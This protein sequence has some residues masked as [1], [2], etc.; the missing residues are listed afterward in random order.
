MKT[1]IH[2]EYFT[3]AV[4]HCANC[5][6]KRTTGATKKEIRIEI[7]SNCHPFYTGKKV[8]ID[9]EGRVDFCNDQSL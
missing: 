9:T 7:C 8:L 3:D 4:I 6:F 5:D 2:P 1:A